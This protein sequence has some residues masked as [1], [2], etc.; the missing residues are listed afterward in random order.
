[1]IRDIIVRTIVIAA[2]IVGLEPTGLWTWLGAHPFWSS[3][4][5]FFGV[6]AGVV[7]WFLTDWLVRRTHS[8]V[9]SA[10][11]ILAVAIIVTGTLSWYGKTEFAASLADNRFAGQMWYF[12]F[13]AF[14]ACIFATLAMLSKIIV[15]TIRLSMSDE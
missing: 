14:I 7:L 2:V 4:V 5:A 11:A 1:M 12:G 15:P 8:A 3:R 10:I 6:A 13:I 9:S